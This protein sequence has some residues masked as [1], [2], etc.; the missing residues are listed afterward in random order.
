MDIVEEPE[1]SYYR[2]CLIHVDG[3]LE[4][5]TPQMWTNGQVNQGFPEVK[6]SASFLGKIIQD[7]LVRDHLDLNTTVEVTSKVTG[8]YDSIRDNR[9][10][11]AVTLQTFPIQDYE[12]VLPYQVL[13]E[14]G[15][16]ILSSYTLRDLDHIT[17]ADFFT[18]SLN[19][20]SQNLWL[21]IWI[22]FWVFCLFLWIRKKVNP[23][24]KLEPRSVVYETLCHLTGCETTDFTDKSG[25]MISLTM[26][27]GFFFLSC[28][29]MNLMST[30][31]VVQEKPETL[32]SYQDMMN[33]QN[34][35]P[36]FVDGLSDINVFSDEV[37]ETGIHYK[38]WQ[39]FKDNAKV[40]DATMDPTSLTPTIFSAVE[41]QNAAGIVTSLFIKGGQKML[42]KC[43]VALFP[44]FKSVYTWLASDPHQKRQTSGMI[45]RQ[46]IRSTI[47]GRT[48][49]KA[50]LSMFE[51]GVVLHIL[52]VLV[53]N[54]NLA[55]ILESLPAS[56]LSREEHHHQ[57]EMCVSTSVNYH[58]VIVDKAVL[59][60][61]RLLIIV[62]ICLVVISFLALMREFYA[63]RLRKARR[64]RNN[65]LK[66]SQVQLQWS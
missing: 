3:M 44:M 50:L 31:M 55:G 16:Q 45:M 12:V 32:N 66:M 19:S 64:S 23:Q 36:V 26:T 54:I 5:K 57:M 59:A 46:A 6:G 49:R 13:V 52:D 22:M 48:A 35:T 41:K 8:C 58:A 40:V 30:E 29:Y 17:Y 24:K 60:N 61:F 25:Q 37:H 62:C 4:L 65:R 11:F 9:T 14:W 2:I 63:D 1:P 20:F 53:D 47:F 34:M 33:K 56:V 38:F 15:L 42:C 28:C 10:D 39:K 7:I 43:K 51:S 18:T 27:V 21:L